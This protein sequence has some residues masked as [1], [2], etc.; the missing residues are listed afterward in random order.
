MQ[1]QVLVV[2]FSLFTTSE[3]QGQSLRSGSSYLDSTVAAKRDQSY[4]C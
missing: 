4:T 1:F 3:C 2:L